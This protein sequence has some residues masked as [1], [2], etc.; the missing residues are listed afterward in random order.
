MNQS[1]ALVAAGAFDD[2]DHALAYA[3]ENLVTED[4]DDG[5]WAK[6]LVDE[7]VAQLDRGE[8]LTHEEVWA[9]VQSMIAGKT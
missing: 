1:C 2:M 4:D 8:R 5:S 6:P 9:D 7:A 3:I